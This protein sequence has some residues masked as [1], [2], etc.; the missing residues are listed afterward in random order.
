MTI[1]IFHKIVQ[2]TKG[3][4]C[5]GGGEPTIHPK[6]WEFL[7]LVWEY[8]TDPL[9]VGL[10]TNGSMTETTLKL[11]ALAKEGKLACILSLDKYHAP[12]DPAVVQAFAGAPQGQAFAGAPQGYPYQGIFN[13]DYR[14]IRDAEGKESN[15]GR[16][17]WGEEF[18]CCTG[19]FVK[20]SGVIRACGCLDAPVIG[21]VQDG[22]PSTLPTGCYKNAGVLV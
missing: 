21:H 18:C 17:D 7:D 20:P 12:I 5:L 4:L 2:H 11:A 16:C 15:N 22:F 10:V 6:F 19:A 3:H 8:A 9:E 1:G 13:T 14:A